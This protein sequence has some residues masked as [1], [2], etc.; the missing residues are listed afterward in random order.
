MKLTDSELKMV[1]GGVK[2]DQNTGIN[3]IENTMPFCCEK[4]GANFD[5]E[6][7]VREA[8]CPNCGHRHVIDG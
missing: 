6:L 5:I 1:S 2:T 7:G 3:N 8:E 4:C